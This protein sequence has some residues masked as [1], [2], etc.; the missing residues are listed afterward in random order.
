[1]PRKLRLEYPGA[2]Y[3]VINRGNYRSDVFASEGAKQAFERTLFEAC[4]KWNWLLYAFVLMRNHFHLAVG[5]PQA[6]LVLGMQ[7]LQATYANRFNRLRKEQGHLFQ[8]R[9]RA[10]V[11]GDEGALGSVCDYIHL[12]PIRAGM[13][14]LGTLG[15]HRYSSYWYL[16]HPA[17]RPPFLRVESALVEAGIKSDN[18]AGWAAYDQRLELEICGGLDV[19]RKYSHLER[20]WAIGSDAFKASLIADHAPVGRA[21]AWTLPGAQQMRSAQWEN[22]LTQALTALNRNLS[23]AIREPKSAIWKLALATWMRD[24]ARARNNWL[25]ERLNLGNPTEVSRNLSRYRA[26]QQ[27]N[28][29]TWTTLTATFST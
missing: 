24:T 23:Q 6:N 20:G 21:R 26:Q 29:P 2:R 10:L 7:W 12:N 1:M 18:P 5:T 15:T 25:S 9:Y 28:D 22:A 14:P 3:H 13:V 4:L 19:A 16:R 27:L 17:S 11:I 8:G